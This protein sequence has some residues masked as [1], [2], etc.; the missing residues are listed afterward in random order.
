[1]VTTVRQAV[2]SGDDRL[3]VRDPMR[4]AVPSGD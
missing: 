4:Q 3:S 2:P 1:M